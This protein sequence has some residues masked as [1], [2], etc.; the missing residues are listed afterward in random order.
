MIKGILIG[1]I[2][3]LIVLSAIAYVRQPGCAYAGEPIAPTGWYRVH[4][5][6]GNPLWCHQ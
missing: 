4:E 2:A 3:T 1:I 5:W 6:Q